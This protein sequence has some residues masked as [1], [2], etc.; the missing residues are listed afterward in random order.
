[1][2][3]RSS[4]RKLVLAGMLAAMGALLIGPLAIKL[5]LLGGFIK[6]ISFGC[7]PVLFA[8]AVLGPVWGAVTGAAADILSF[9]IAG[10]GA[11]F[12]GFTMTYAL[13]GVL[14]GMLM[15]NVGDQPSYWRVLL[16][17]AVSYIVCF[18]IINSVILVS[19]FALT[20]SII[21]I[22]AGIQCVMVPI[23]ALLV[24]TLLLAVRSFRPALNR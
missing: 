4:L 23:Y 7:V 9:L 13:C 22:R 3:K 21:F 19:W 11:Y 18:T 17:T 10:T 12:P 16:A 14:S 5:N 6:N 2:L 24:R 20:P 15:Q 1:M 8:G